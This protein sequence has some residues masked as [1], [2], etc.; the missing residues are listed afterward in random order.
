MKKIL[1]YLPSVIFLTAA[2]VAAQSFTFSSITLSKNALPGEYVQFNA[3]VINHSAGTLSMKLKR[4]VNDILSGWTSSLCTPNGCYPPEVS[5]VGFSV[6]AGDTC[7]IDLDVTSDWNHPGVGII[8]LRVYPTADSTNYQDLTFTLSAVAT[9]VNTD[10]HTNIQFKL[11]GNYPNPFNPST[12]ITYQIPA[13]REVTLKIYNLLG[14]EIR[15]L[16]QG[17]PRAGI[18]QVVWDGRNDAGSP[19]SAGIYL[20]RLQSGTYQSTKKMT[21][22]K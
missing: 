1:L 2:S 17:K 16:V 15:T 4:T 22:V 8:T 11:L 12:V 9:S 7:P 5:L 13:S 21:L 3:Q 19:V 18:H 20:Y 10:L 6:A 14:Q